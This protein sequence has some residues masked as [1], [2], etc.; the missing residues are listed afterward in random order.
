MAEEQTP[1]RII[2]FRAENFKKLK[3]VE[4]RPDTD[5][6]EITGR[7]G[8]GK[9]SVLDAILAALGGTRE[10]QMK[11]IRT[12]CERASIRLDLG[13]ILIE[14]RFKKD[15]ENP[16]GYTTDVIVSTA[17]G[18]RFKKPQDILDALVGDFTFDPLAFARMPA[19]EQFEALKKLVPGVDFAAHERADREDFEAR[20]TENRNAATYKAQADAIILPA[21]KVP[22]RVDVEELETQLAEAGERNASIERAQDKRDGATNRITVIDEQMRVLQGER[23][24]LQKALDEAKPLP[25]PIDTAKVRADLTA[26]REGN[27]I[28]D[29]A[30]RRR[31][32]E[33]Q[34]TAEKDKADARTKAMKEREEQRRQAVAKAKMPIKGLGFGDGYLTLNDEPFEQA[35]D[36]QQLQASIALAAF[37]NPRLRIARV[38]DGNHLDDIARIELERFAASNNLQVWVERVDSSGTIGFALENGELKSDQPEPEEAV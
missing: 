33:A 12:G 19:K 2:E 8:Q 35:S 37:M 28:A 38:R 23:D 30:D 14:R 10:I 32:L 29:K 5:V 34:A 18:S 21:G 1:L 9:T 25:P 6:V 7:N 13:E 17:E 26:A 24:E 36:A 22:A 4:I 31:A 15:D 27:A 20:T 11:P 3:I 16:K